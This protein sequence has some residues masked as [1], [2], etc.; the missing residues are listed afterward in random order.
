MFPTAKNYINKLLDLFDQ[1]SKNP[2]MTETI[3]LLSEYL[4]I[5][6]HFL[7]NWLIVAALNR[8][9]HDLMGWRMNTTPHHRPHSIS[10]RRAGKEK[11]T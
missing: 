10:F 7:S 1:K 2:A 5:A 11:V 6:G 8:E 4:Q 9:E 3:I